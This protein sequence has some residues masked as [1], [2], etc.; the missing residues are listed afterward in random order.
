MPSG[1]QKPPLSAQVLEIITAGWLAQAVSAAA[2]LGVA[3]V[4]ADGPRPVAEIAAE[5]GSHAPSLYRLLRAGADLGLF[6]E[7][8]DKV[9]ELTELGGTLRAD[10]PTSLRNFAIWTGLPAERHAWAGLA[11][12]VRTGRT[13]FTEVFGKPV[14]DYFHEHPEVLG[15][16]DRAMTEASRQIIA[17]VVAAYDFGRFGTVV[18]A[19]GGRGALLAAVLASAPGTRGVLYDRPEVIEGAGQPLREAG[20]ADRAELRSGDFFES[21]PAGADAVILS[22]IIHD[23][24][25]EQS[26]RILV[27]AREALTDGGHVLLVEAVLPDRPRP[28]PTVSLMDLDMLV[29]AGGQQRTAAEFETLLADSGLKL[30]RI[31][32]G[33]HCS[34]VEAVRA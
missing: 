14:W 23:W 29:V 1:P 3:D 5:T 16:F 9:F 32:P 17:P 10:S 19:G 11:D 24:D 6:T 22:N 12:A 13:P 30:S 18:D 21:V 34:I 2:E 15:V 33:G 31:V 28:R 8:D 26:R 20:V 7:H 27:N 25:D 4:L